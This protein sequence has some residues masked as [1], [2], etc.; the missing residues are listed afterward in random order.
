MPEQRSRINDNFFREQGSFGCEGL[1]FEEE[2]L[3]SVFSHESL[4]LILNAHCLQ[5]YVYFSA[6]KIEMVSSRWGL[7]LAAGGSVSFSLLMTAGD[8]HS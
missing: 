1:A 7:A 4:P 8:L 6:S 5:L 2:K 3:Q